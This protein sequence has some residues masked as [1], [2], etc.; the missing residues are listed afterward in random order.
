[1]EKYSAGNI[2][3]SYAASNGAREVATG[4]KIDTKLQQLREKARAAKIKTS[5]HKNYGWTLKCPEQGLYNAFFY[6]SSKPPCSKILRYNAMQIN[7]LQT[8]K[9][10][11]R[12][13]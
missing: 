4:T 7:Y 3:L 5:T 2:S 13:S 12:V 9:T 1:V 6:T 8:L 11:Q 10:L